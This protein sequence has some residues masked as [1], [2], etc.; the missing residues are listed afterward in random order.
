MRLARL[1]RGISQREMANA[2][3]VTQATYS[4]TEAGVNR[5]TDENL[6]KISEIL[7][8]PVRRLFEKTRVDTLD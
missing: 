5:A 4:R 3:G 8:V 2:L 7:G 1:K 6:H